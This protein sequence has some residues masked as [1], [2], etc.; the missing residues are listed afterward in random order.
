MGQIYIRPLEPHDA[1]RLLEL[2][3]R[4]REF[5]QPFE[6]IRD[7]T[8]FTIDGQ[9]AEIAN[10]AVSAKNDQAYA[11]GIFLAETDEIIG[12]IALT[13]ITRGPAQHANVG[14]FI[15]QAHNG[16]GYATKAV[17]LAVQAA[18]DELGLHCVQAGVMPRN[19][20]SARVLTKAGFRHEGLAKRYIKINGAW[21]DHDLFAI[22][23]EDLD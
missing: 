23:V 22:T 14:Y 21:E 17:E 4:N 12:R 2:K 3:R 6:P 18:F 9:R 15:D 13:G 19:A 20:R 7:E 1:E 8:H 16:K 5:F 11:F 10:G